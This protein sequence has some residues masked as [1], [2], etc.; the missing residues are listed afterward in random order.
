MGGKKL[1]Q[2][3]RASCKWESFWN[4]RKSKG[5]LRTL[6][7]CA[8]ALYPFLMWILKLT[9]VPIPLCCMPV[10]QNRTE[11]KAWYLTQRSNFAAHSNMKGYTLLLQYNTCK[12]ISPKHSNTELWKKKDLFALIKNWSLANRNN[13]PLLSTVVLRDRNE[14]A[15]WF[16]PASR[17][18]TLSW[19]WMLLLQIVKRSPADRK[20]VV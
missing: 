13:V 3:K 20:S 9:C 8:P 10:T 7:V 14:C 19:I 6:H 1:N 16:S 15:C 2:L 11:Y 12:N 4:V 17:F 18:N 5:H